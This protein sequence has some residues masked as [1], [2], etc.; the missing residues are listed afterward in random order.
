MGPG[1]RSQR[2]VCSHT[3]SALRRGAL[4]GPSGASR[5]TC[6]AWD[7]ETDGGP[8]ELRRVCSAEHHGGLPGRC[9]QVTNPSR[10]Q[11]PEPRGKRAIQGQHPAQQRAGLSKRMA[12]RSQSRL[13][14]STARVLS[15]YP[16]PTCPANRPRPRAFCAERYSQ[17]GA[18]T[19]SGPTSGTCR[20][21][22]RTGRSS[23][24]P[25]AAAGSC[26]D[27]RG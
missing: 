10:V 6:P 2:C 13:Q 27:L 22:T 3:A 24:G 23:P 12:L 8:S 25:R 7:T 5:L 20:W 18:R 15:L 16:R 1:L 9:S 19:R 17:R 21:R 14:A 11:C 4:C 26:P